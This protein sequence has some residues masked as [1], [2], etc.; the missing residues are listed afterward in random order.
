MR[1]KPI[2]HLVLATSLLTIPVATYGEGLAGA[3]LAANHA[4]ARNDYA[5]A[6]DT[7]GHHFSQADLA[8]LT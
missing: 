3:Y 2:F 6:E 5:A 7:A 1:I 4:N 8:A